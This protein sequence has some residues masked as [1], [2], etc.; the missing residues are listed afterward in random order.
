MKKQSVPIYKII[1][2]LKLQKIIIQKLQK[3]YNSKITCFAKLLLICDI[4]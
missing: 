2:I 3:N 1:I 4:K